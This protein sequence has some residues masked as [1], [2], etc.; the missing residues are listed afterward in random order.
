MNRDRYLTPKAVCRDLHISNSTLWNWVASGHL[1]KPVKIGPRATRFRLEDI[2][3]FEREAL[4]R[5]HSDSSV[6][7]ISEANR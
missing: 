7:S 2:E 1:P 4:S 3:R 5:S 6:H